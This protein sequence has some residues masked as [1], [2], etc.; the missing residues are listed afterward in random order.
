MIV[1]PAAAATETPVAG[2]LPRYELAAWGRRFGLV[3]GI[4]A[5]DG[6]FNLGLLTPAP[7]RDVV[8]RWRAFA[9]AMRPGFRGL[10]AGLQ[11]HGADIAG[12]AS[13]PDGWLIVDGKDGHVTNVPG[14]LV[15][16]S[17]ADC[18]PI[19]LAHP[20]SGTVAL[21]HAGW[22]GVAAGILEAGIAAVAGMGGGSPADLVMHCGVAICGQCYEVGPEVVTALTG[23]PA[24]GPERVDLR[25]LLAARARASGIGDVSVSPWCSAHDANLF[26]SHRRSAGA[27]GRMLAYLGRPLA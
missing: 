18:V 3:A 15:L 23:A 1:A 27:D 6:D 14:L 21:L 11:V 12:H 9:A 22:R 19:Y 17:V 8:A 16:V 7:A 10:A 20:T 4:T 24:H 2:S 26:Y 25:A 13:A 5:R